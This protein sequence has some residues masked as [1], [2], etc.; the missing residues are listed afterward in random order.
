MLMRAVLSDLRPMPVGRVLKPW[1][2]VALLA[3]LALGLAALVVGAALP[4]ASGAYA[5]PVQNSYSSAPGLP[6]GRVYEEV[7]P[8]NKY[9]SNA[10]ALHLHKTEENP[11]GQDFYWGESVAS[12]DGNGMFFGGTGP[13]G[14]SV[15]GLDSFFVAQRTSTGWSTRSALPRALG[16]EGEG[17]PGGLLD[18]VQYAPPQ[19]VDPAAD[20]SSVAFSSMS[21]YTPSPY[22]IKDA[23]E[24]GYVYLAG[25]DPLAAPSWLTRPGSGTVFRGS[26][27]S[28][29]TILDGG[30]PDLSTVYFT[31]SNTY[32]LPQDA[33]RNQL[34]EANHL[35][36][37]PFGFYQYR[38]GALSVAGVLP[39]G[40]VSAYG[41]VPA[42]MAGGFEPTGSNDVRKRFRYLN[43]DRRNNEVANNGSRAFFVSPDPLYSLQTPAS[44]EQE[45]CQV[46]CTAAAPELYVLE[47]APDG[48]QST[49]LVSQSQ[50]PG[51]VGQP[52]SSGVPR[53]LYASSD[54]SH[55]FF[56]SADRLTEAAPNDE[57]LKV[58]NFDVDTDTLTY[59][60]GVV[61]PI[62][63]V[64]SDGSS[65]FFENTATS[66]TELDRWVAEPGGG[67]ITPVVQGQFEG[68]YGY[69]ARLSANG[70]VLVFEGSGIA[71]FNDGRH[72]EVFRYEIGSKEL[73]CVSCPPSGI[74]PS[75]SAVMS[76]LAA[77]ETTGVSGVAEARNG[78]VD[79][80]VISSDGSRVFFESPDPLVPQDTDGKRDVYEWE[81]GTV[82]LISSGASTDDSLILD[83]SESGDDVFFAT[84]DAL[85]PGD[86]EG[87]YDVYDA[88]V[89][90]PG[91]NPPPSA[92]PCQGEVCQ[93]PP[94]VPSLLGAP[95]S[96]TFNGAGNIV[97][98]ESTAE[99]AVKPKSKPVKC[100]RGHVKKRG[101]CVRKPTARKRDH[102]RGR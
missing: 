61:G 84:A 96:A 1:D 59:L 29:E 52:E 27:S 97:P 39:D 28:E 94:S 100:E 12:A 74:S 98:P 33:S 22:G 95:A 66:P 16:L 65:F 42:A 47:T 40:S 64:A 11:E 72:K 85:V 6:D 35:E 3:T 78:V 49:V 57:S 7:S 25:S 55:A 18:P 20:L 15:S 76:N 31:S 46:T 102:R 26:S 41:A 44:F 93:G 92:V 79:D 54:G 68:R 17:G 14:E 58:Y 101:R 32:G 21:P 9:S 63:A 23:A 81:N 50:L 77:Y 43:V 30:T 73:S 88:R 75:R 62:V 90:H 51:Q 82:F 53:F 38:N 87:G 91:D 2:R 70:S 56:A 36:E 4:A 71:G 48:T 60:P 19:W 5:T 13:M 80:R 67:S 89:P 86:T 83:N 24:F 45:G 99:P 34:V 10:G 37:A 8:P 69:E